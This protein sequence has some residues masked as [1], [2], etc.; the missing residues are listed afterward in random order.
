MLEAEKAI[1]NLREQKARDREAITRLGAPLPE[2]DICSTCWFMHGRRVSL[3]IVS[4]SVV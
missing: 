4:H 1:A 3:M 2:P